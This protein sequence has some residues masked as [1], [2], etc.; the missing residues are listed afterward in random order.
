MNQLNKIK[1]MALCLWVGG[2]FMIGGLVAPVLFMNLPD[3]MTA[4]MLAGKCFDIQTWVNLACAVLIFLVMLLENQSHTFKKAGFWLLLIMVVCVVVSQF[5]ITP[6]I[7]QLKAGRVP[8]AHGSLGP[9]FAKWHGISSSIYWL[10]AL[11]G[12][13]LIWNQVPRRAD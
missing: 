13:L 2:L 1:I 12:V 9:E 10:Q 3:K 5:G 11:L 8:D 7:E 6:I 4:G